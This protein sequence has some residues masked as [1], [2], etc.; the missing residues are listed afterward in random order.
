MIIVDG[1]TAIAG[2]FNFAN[3]AD[4]DNDENRL[5][6]DDRAVAQFFQVE[7]ERV[8]AVAKNPPRMN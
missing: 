8:L 6:V 5:I 2:S 1:R 7:F 4:T 3:N